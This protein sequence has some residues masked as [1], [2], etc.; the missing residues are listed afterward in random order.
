LAKRKEKG[1]TSGPCP[2]LY[3][4]QAVPS[5]VACCRVLTYIYPFLSIKEIAKSAEI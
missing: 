1:M 5:F 4:V 3:V 2:Y